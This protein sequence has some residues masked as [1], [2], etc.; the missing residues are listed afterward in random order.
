MKRAFFLNPG[1]KLLDRDWLESFILS[2]KTKQNIK[3]KKAYTI[4]FFDK[5]SSLHK[6][7]HILDFSSV[8]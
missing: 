7:Y 8:N 6:I 5:Q 4:R 1:K 2:I 3:S